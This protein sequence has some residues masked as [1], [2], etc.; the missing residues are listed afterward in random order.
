MLRTVKISFLLLALLVGLNVLTMFAGVLTYTRLG[1]EKEIARLS[2]V[3]TGENAYTATFDNLLAGSTHE[4]PLFGDQWQVDARFL[5]LAPWANV[6][7]FDARY[8]LDR[9]SGRYKNIADQ[10]NNK[11]LSHALSEAA[12]T[13]PFEKVYE[14]SL[15]FFFIDAEYGNATYQDIDPDKVYSV[16]RTQT[17]IITRPYKSPASEAQGKSVMHAVKHWLL[18]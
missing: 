6:L 18:E 4:Y 2:F 1:D 14:H 17:G 11:K 9:L 16:Y 15:L 12:I 13:D 3:A 10:N 7:G 5:K 8:K